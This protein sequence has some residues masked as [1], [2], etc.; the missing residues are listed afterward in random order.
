MTYSGMKVLEID[1]ETAP[2][3]AYVWSLFDTH[4][5]IDR[6]VS[7]GY[8]LCF[9]ARWQHEEK[10]RFHAVWREGE[11][12]MIAAA[13]KLLNQADAVVH[14][15]GKKFDIPTLNREFVLKGLSPPSNYQQIDLYHVV[16][17]RFRFASNKLDFVCQ[18]LELGAKT[19][20]KGMQ[21]WR[22]VMAGDKTAQKTMETYNIQDTALLGKLYQKLQPWVNNHPNRGL[23]IEDTETPICRNCGSTDVKRNGREMRFTLCYHRYKCNHCGA[24]LRSRLN[25]NSKT[26]SPILV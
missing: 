18:Q 21:L 2:H 6:V 20:H 22:E 10:M 13:W 26:T 15:N 3:I 11:D 16:R 5:P 1:I 17:Q 12:K 8:T 14:Y 19:Q 7:S 4:V 24:N 9:A 25:V 23:W